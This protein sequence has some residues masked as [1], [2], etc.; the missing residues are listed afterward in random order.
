MYI[1]KFVI[2]ARTTSGVQIYEPFRVEVSFQNVSDPKNH[3]PRAPKNILSLFSLILL[4]SLDL[5]IFL[6]A[7]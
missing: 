1:R 4:V 6:K 3:G 5:E 7:Q 2:K